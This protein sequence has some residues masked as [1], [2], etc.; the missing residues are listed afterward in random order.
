[1]K[2]RSLLTLVAVILYSITSFGQNDEMKGFFDFRWDEDLGKVFLTVKE[3]DKEFLYVNSLAAG[4]GS[5]DIG[6][7][8]GQLGNTR[9]VKFTK[10]G[11]KILLIQPNYDYRAESDN[12]EEVKSVREAFAQSVIWGFE[13]LQGDEGY[14][15][16]ISDFLMRDSHGVA[17]RLSSQ[18]QG[19]YGIDPSRTALYKPAIK[20]FPKNSE[21]EAMITFKGQAKGYNIRSVTPSPDAITVRMHHSFI[22]LPDDKYEKREFDPRAGYFGITYQDYATP[23]DQPLVKRFI[24]RHRL[25]KKDP[26]AAISEAKE[27]IVYYVDRGAPEPVSSALIEGASWWNQAFEAAGFKDAFRVELL[28]EGVDPLDVRYNVI[29]WVHRST[30]GWSYGASVTDPRTGEIIKGHVSLGSLRVRQDFLIA[31]G[32]MQPYDGGEVSDEMMKMALARLRQLS[33]HE[34]GHTL[35]LAHNFAASFNDRASVM[36][37]PHPYFALN[38]DGSINLDDAYDVGIGEWDKVAIKYGYGVYENESAMKKALNDAFDG[39]MKFI[40]DQD[41]RPLGGAHAYAHLWDNGKNAAEELNRLL[42]VR[43]KILG[44]FSMDAIPEGAPVSSIEEVLVPMY[45]MHRYQMEAAVKLIGGLDFSYSVKGDG[46]S[47]P[48]MIAPPIQKDALHSLT[49]VIKAEN[50]MLPDQ[51]LELIPP[52]AYGYYRTRESFK[53]KTGVAFDGI[54]PAATISDQVFGMI[55]HPERVNRLLEHKSRETSQ[56]GLSFVID[57]LMKHTWNATKYNGYAREVQRAVESQ[58][59]IALFQLASSEDVQIQANAIAFQKIKELESSLKKQTKK[60]V[61]DE[62]AHIN[63]SLKMIT[64]YYKKP[65]I[66]KELSAP[67]PPDGSPIGTIMCSFHD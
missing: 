58:L 14:I 64:D 30:R 49:E 4:V 10:V 1:M 29:Q 33:A 43:K 3:L 20:N 65:E 53:S 23:I 18:N 37:Y 67:N 47:T 32:L 54:T 2:M 19:N 42:K 27:P 63:F 17:S 39:G 40:T 44:E 8:R 15:I 35:G 61:G 21:F 34:V 11:N 6:L 36:D 13:P 60:A 51:V 31:Q 55:L 45:F 50:L 16:D 9:V 59:L 62:A 24:S 48:Q 26:N 7:D 56:L 57:D 52:R 66:Y 38:D 25:E 41:A 12:L 5:N 28:P 22:E 46:S